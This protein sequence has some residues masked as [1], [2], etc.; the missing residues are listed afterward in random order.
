ML[1]TEGFFHQN[2][3]LLIIMQRSVVTNHDDLSPYIRCSSLGLD[4][5]ADM[6]KVEGDKIEPKKEESKSEGLQFQTKYYFLIFT[7]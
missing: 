6:A 3:V 2:G 7:I 5:A 4:T 1:T